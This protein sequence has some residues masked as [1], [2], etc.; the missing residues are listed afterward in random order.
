MALIDNDAILNE[1]LD[2]D[3]VK[4][5]SRGQGYCSCFP[6]CHSSHMSGGFWSG[7]DIEIGRDVKDDQ[8]VGDNY[9]LVILF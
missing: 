6:L 8:F 1:I 9:V 2:P 4:K 3:L 5:M 7:Y